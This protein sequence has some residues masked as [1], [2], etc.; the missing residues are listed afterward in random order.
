MMKKRLILLVL[1]VSVLWTISSK[2]LAYEVTEVKDGATIQ[3]TVTLEGAAPPP[4]AYNLITFPDP[5]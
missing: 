2:A 4:K 1:L 3:G 5:E